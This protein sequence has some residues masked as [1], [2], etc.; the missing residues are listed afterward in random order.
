[1][2]FDIH[3]ILESLGKTRPI[4]H[5]EADFQHALAWEIHTRLPKATVRLEIPFS[6]V[7]HVDCLVKTATSSVFI[8]LKYKTSSLRVLHAGDKYAL[9][10]HSAQDC[11]RYDFVKDIQRLEQLTTIFGGH[12]LAVFLSNDHGFWDKT[13]R[14]STVDAAFRM[15]EGACFKKTLEWGKNASEGTTKGRTRPIS[16][17]GEYPIRWRDY[18][19]VQADA[20]SAFR[21]CVVNVCPVR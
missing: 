2:D 8:E 1:M 11:A 21:Y 18:S 20:L 4:F 17:E 3:S 19:E 12:G 9:R 7:G 14:V 13:K 10:N 16:L 5:S 15:H 6:G